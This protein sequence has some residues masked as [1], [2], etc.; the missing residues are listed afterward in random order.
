MGWNPP[1]SG[2]QLQVDVVVNCAS[3]AATGGL[4]QYGHMAVTGYESSLERLLQQPR[5]ATSTWTYTVVYFATF[6]QRETM[7][8][9]EIQVLRVG[10]IDCLPRCKFNCFI[11]S[12]KRPILLNAN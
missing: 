4:Q 10:Y 5:V 11:V 6:S 12:P 2:L 7:L 9:V 1:D 3:P 8:C